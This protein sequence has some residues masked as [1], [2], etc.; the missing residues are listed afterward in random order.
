LKDEEKSNKQL[1]GGL[2]EKRSYWNLKERAL[3]GTL[4]RTRFPRG[5]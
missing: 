5:Y 4:W 2:K 3:A 1:L